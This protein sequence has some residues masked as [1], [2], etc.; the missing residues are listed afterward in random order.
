[1]SPHTQH[2]QNIT[3]L[4]THC[5]AAKSNAEPASSLKQ[6]N[7]SCYK[8]ALL[9]IVRHFKIG[10]SRSSIKNQESRTSF[11]AKNQDQESRP[12]SRWLTD[13]RALYV[14]NMFG[15][16]SMHFNVSGVSGGS[17]E[18]ATLESLGRLMLSWCR[19]RGALL[20]S[21]SHALVQTLS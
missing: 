10:D 16:T 8:L 2:R 11:K 5:H 1:M 13:S 14:L 3:N 9:G 12:R 18:P 6:G 17:I 20:G 19:F 15:Q 21:V 7:D 4:I